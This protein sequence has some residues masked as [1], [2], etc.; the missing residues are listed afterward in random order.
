MDQFENK[1]DEFVLNLVIYT[2]RFLNA[3]FDYGGNVVCKQNKNFACLGTKQ[4][5]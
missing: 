2:L 3:T 5:N 1:F 4:E